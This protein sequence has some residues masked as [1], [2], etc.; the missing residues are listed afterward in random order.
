MAFA[1]KLRNLGI[2][3]HGLVREL[4]APL[5]GSIYGGEGHSRIYDDDAVYEQALEFA[6]E[7]TDMDAKAYHKLTSLVS[8]ASL[9][10]PNRRNSSERGVPPS[11]KVAN[12]IR[13]RGSISASAQPGIAPLF[14]KYELPPSGTNANPY[15]LPWALRGILEEPA[16]KRDMQDEVEELIRLFDEWKPTSKVLK[17]VRFRLEAVKSKL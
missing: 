9:A 4:S 8:P 1:L 2:S 11:P 10:S 6:L 17:D 15:F 5:A 13:S 3:D 16:V 14:T 7:T 12:S